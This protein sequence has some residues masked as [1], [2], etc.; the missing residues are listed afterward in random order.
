[1][2]Q[3]QGRTALVTGSTSGIGRA[4]ATAFAAHGAHVMLNGF[5]DAKEI[6]A[7]RADLE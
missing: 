6:E 3:F 5:G 2:K 7:L 1:M 4:M